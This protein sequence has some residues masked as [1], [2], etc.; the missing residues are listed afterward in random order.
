MAT[1]SPHKPFESEEPRRFT[2]EEYFDMEYVSETRHEFH[3]GLI[4]PVAY[5]SENHGRIVSNLSFELQKC[6]RETDCDVFAT[7]RM[8]FVPKCN[9]VFYPDILV[10]C[11]KREY[12]QQSK[13]MVATLNPQILIEVLSD[14]TEDFD[15]REKMRCYRKIPSLQQYIMVSQHEKFVEIQKNDG[16]NRWSSDLYEEDEDVLDLG[17]CRVLLKDIYLKVVFDAPERVSE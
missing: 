2:V 3:N 8:L 10:V 13:N 4:L 12:Y 14:S 7:E 1:Q 15:K 5:T 9:K 6:L 16:Q 17:E 11:G